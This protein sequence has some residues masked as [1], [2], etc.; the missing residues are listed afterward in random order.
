MLFAASYATGAQ[1]G[2]EEFLNRIE[3]GELKDMSFSGE[4]KIIKVACVGDS[5]TYGATSTKTGRTYPAYIQE[6]LGLDYFVLNAGISGYSIVSTDQYAYCLTEEYAHAKEFA[7]DVVLFALGTN[8]ANPTPSQP[9]KDW[10]NAAND[11]TNRFNQ[12]TNELL[13]SFIEINPDVQIYMLI[14]PSLFKVGN[15]SWSAE[16]W[17]EGLKTHVIPLLREI[18]EKRGLK[19]IELFDWSLEHKEVFVDGL[20]PKDESYKTFAQF[21]YDSIKDTIKKP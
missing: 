18:S 15:D 17:T 6:M 19:T 4:K 21:I 11:R 16:K 7:P 14:P 20:H 5:I 8:D 13:D 3:N 9:Y 2:S 1:G 10:D 12:S